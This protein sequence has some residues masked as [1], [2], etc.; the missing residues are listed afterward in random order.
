[1]VTCQVYEPSRALHM[2]ELES[3]RSS[4]MLK[5]LPL[6]FIHKWCEHLRHTLLLRCLPR[7]LLLPP[8]ARGTSLPLWVTSPKCGSSIPWPPCWGLFPLSLLSHLLRWLQPGTHRPSKLL[9][10]RISSFRL[11]PAWPP[12]PLLGDSALAT[13]TVPWLHQDRQSVGLS[14]LPFVISSLLSALPSLFNFESW[15]HLSSQA[16]T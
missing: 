3:S 10:S 7:A 15:V 16:L 12:P 8:Q 6:R 1:M 4:R 13:T 14:T 2:W 9:T 11:L 5:H